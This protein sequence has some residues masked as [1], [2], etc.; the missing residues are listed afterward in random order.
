MVNN[1]FILQINRAAYQT[2]DAARETAYKKL[3]EENKKKKDDEDGL[4]A[5]N[6]IKPARESFS[7]TKDEETPPPQL[8]SDVKED[9]HTMLR[10]GRAAY[11]LADQTRKATG[12]IASHAAAGNLAK[13]E[14]YLESDP[15]Y[16][17][18]GDTLQNTTKPEVLTSPNSVRGDL[19]NCPI[20]IPDEN[21]ICDRKT[22]LRDDNSVVSIQN[23][24]SAPISN[25]GSS[26][27]SNLTNDDNPPNNSRLNHMTMSDFTFMAVE[28]MRK[29]QSSISP[30]RQNNSSSKVPMHLRGS[31]NHFGSKIPTNSS[32][33]FYSNTA[34]PMSTIPIPATMIPGP[35]GMSYVLP[36]SNA[37]AVSSDHLKTNKQQAIKNYFS[38]QAT[39]P[40][41]VGSFHGM[42]PPSSA[43]SIASAS[44]RRSKRHKQ[45]VIKEYFSAHS[46]A[47]SLVKNS[48]S[49]VA[50]SYAISEMRNKKQRSKLSSQ[51]LSQEEVKSR[52]FG[53]RSKA[54]NDNMM[55]HVDHGYGGYS[56]VD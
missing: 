16:H 21:T 33:T 1:N 50:S 46:P 20:L 23:G 26:V 43:T 25:D 2:A 56:V 35:N 27:V 40:A 28:K 30:F 31:L 10:V 29:L 5:S 47:P 38:N 41:S 8:I 24:N 14:G 32:N 13:S 19:S 39:V 9:D 15:K 4:N 36:S 3:E 6:E 22:T 52:L 51:P 44:T 49:T 18:R 17:E 54:A 37:P 34:M 11:I 42:S 7:F 45:Q 53:D 55:S 12:T 48:T